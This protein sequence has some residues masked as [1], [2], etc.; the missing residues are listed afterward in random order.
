MLLGN[1][2]LLK[3]TGYDVTSRFRSAAKCNQ[4]LHKRPAKCRRIRPVFNVKSPNF[5]R[6]F[7]P[8]C[9]TATPDMTSPPNYG[10]HSSNFEK[11]AENSASDGFVSNFSGA[12]FLLGPIDWSA[13]CSAYQRLYEILV[14][15]IEDRHLS[16]FEKR[17]KIPHP[18]ALG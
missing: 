6:A 10:G 8:T 2:Q 4:I 16:K 7:M 14:E 13:S 18:T 1:S 9:S 12:A 3:S 5:T 11:T 17:P 15:W